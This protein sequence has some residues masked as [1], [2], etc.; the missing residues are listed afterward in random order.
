[1]KKSY[2]R[3]LVSSLII[4]IIGVFVVDYFSHL[5]FSNPMETVPYFFAK[6]AL[7]LI[8][9]FLFLSIID[10]KKK[11]FVKVLIGGVVVAAIWGAYYNVF[12]AVFGYY[13]FGMSL[14]GLSFLGMGI[15]GTG[16]AFGIVHAL[17]FVVGYYASRTISREFK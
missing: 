3:I 15:L 16:I 14:A 7:F 9:S 2:F 4:T 6:A 11:E 10:V 5:F 13:P 8:Y 12:P 17:A 1:M